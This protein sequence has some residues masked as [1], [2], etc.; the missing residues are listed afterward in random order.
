MTPLALVVLG[1]VLALL[2]MRV[3]GFDVLA[4]VIGWLL[5]V[6]G[7]SRV[8]EQSRLFGLARVAAVGA[9]VLSLS[10]LVHPVRTVATGGGTTTSAVQPE[11]VQGV[12]V[13]GYA[14]AMA[15]F[16]VLLSLAVRD[17]GRARGDAATE[18]TFGRFAVLHAVLGAAGAAAI[19]AGLLV[20]EGGT[21]APGVAAPGVPTDGVAGPAAVIL[22]L[23]VL[24]LLALE[25]WFVVALAR[26]RTLPWLS[27]GAPAAPPVTAA[28]DGGSGP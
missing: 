18:R 10:D 15:V 25:I 14:I 17:G 9:G 22:V 26:V 13:L 16:A 7:L 19:A 27:A 24:G 2:D 28:P 20:A 3:Q 4:D 1:Y 21:T 23:A 12:G 8:P 5:V 11:G 6:V